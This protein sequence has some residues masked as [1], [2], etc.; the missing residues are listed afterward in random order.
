MF[1]NVQHELIRSVKTTLPKNLK[2]KSEPVR[3]KL[4][5]YGVEEGLIDFIEQCLVYDPTHRLTAH[6]ALV[7]KWFYVQQKNIQW[8]D[9]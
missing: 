2:E 3:D 9:M 7:H 8:I 5:E 6:D 4:K 1:G